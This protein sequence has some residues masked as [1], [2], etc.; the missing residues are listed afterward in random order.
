MSGTKHKKPPLATETSSAPPHMPLFFR[1]PHLLD[2]TRHAKASVKASDYA[3]AEQTNC[4]PIVIQEFFDMARHYPIVF[5]LGDTP[6][7]VAIL[8]LE[9]T[10][11]FIT[12]DHQWLPH[13]YI[14]AY[15][16]QYPFLFLEQP[17]D[18]RLYLMVDEGAPHY[19]YGAENDASPLYTGDGKPT[20][21]TDNALKF[22][23]ALFGQY[24]TTRA[25][26]EWLKAHDLLIPSHSDV[27][28]ATGKKFKLEGFQVI[29]EKAFRQLPDKSILELRDKNWLAPLSFIL[30]AASNWQRLLNHAE[31]QGNTVA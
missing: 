26:G 24:K 1:D 14:P 2:S 15:V 11:Y 3:F 16:R 17:N 18:D 23:S 6:T 21:V 12:P 7:A 27:H 29:N 31:S 22:C 20:P 4:V 13:H 5:T 9:Q 10:N 19:T 30:A 25:L 28:L 8:G